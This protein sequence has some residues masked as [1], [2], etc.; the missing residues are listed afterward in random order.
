[1]FDA[2]SEN[3]TRAE[4]SRERMSNF[5]FLTS[6]FRYA[7]FFPLLFLFLTCSGCCL[8]NLTLHYLWTVCAVWKQQKKREKKKANAMVE[9]SE[10]RGCG[11]GRKVLQ[12]MALVHICWGFYIFNSV[13]L[14]PRVLISFFFVRSCHVRQFC[15]SI[16]KLPEWCT[17]TLYSQL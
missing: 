4:S 9:V 15:A 10:S 16:S 17:W 6:S 11:G 8:H 12:T 13:D 3:W 7:N 1:M 14:F 2:S 5:T